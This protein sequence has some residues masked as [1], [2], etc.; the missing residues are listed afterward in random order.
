MS[1]A[2]VGLLIPQRVRM[3]SA[4]RG[5]LGLAARAGERQQPVVVLVPRFTA[6]VA[7]DPAGPAGVLAMDLAK[8]DLLRPPNKFVLL[9]LIQQSLL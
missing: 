4:A 6:A 7:V 1:G 8:K 9:I 2:A 3:P 5:A